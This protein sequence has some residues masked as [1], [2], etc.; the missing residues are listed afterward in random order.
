MLDVSTEPCLSFRCLWNPKKRPRK[1]PANKIL[2]CHRIFPLLSSRWSISAT[3]NLNDLRTL[4]PRTSRRWR[5]R[6]PHPDHR[7]ELTTR[8]RLHQSAWLS[9]FT[10]NPCSTPRSDPTLIGRRPQLGKCR[11]EKAVWL[12][13]SCE[14]KIS[15]AGANQFQGLPSIPSFAA[16][17]RAPHK[18]TQSRR[19]GFRARLAR[20]SPAHDAAR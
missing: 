9:G 16:V 1:H 6:G 11:I 12:G 7:R 15:L 5:S 17:A 20:R 2:F 8:C 19:A 4:P 10:A 13:A 18:G 14:L 3:S